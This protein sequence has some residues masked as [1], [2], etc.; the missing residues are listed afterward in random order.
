M[1]GVTPAY[2]DPDGAALVELPE[3]GTDTFA[4]RDRKG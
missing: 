2:L 4:G 3:I 1:S